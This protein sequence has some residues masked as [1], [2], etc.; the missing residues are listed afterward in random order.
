MTIR[1]HPAVDA[2]VLCVALNPAIDLTI[3]VTNLRPG[4][5][6]RAQRAQQ[7]A[8]GKGIN[9]ASCL[10]D[11]GAG[12]A[13]MMEA[14]RILK[15]VGA[16][17]NRTIRVAL[18]TGE[19]QG[20]IGSQAYVAKHF[21]AYPEPTDPAQKALPAA[22]RTNKGKLV[23]TGDYEKITAYFN[24]DNGSGKIR[25]IYAQ[26]NLA[27]APIFEEWLK[28][29]ND[30]GATIVTQRNT[31]STDHVSFD[32]VGI[33]GFQFVQDQL[34]YFSHVHHTHLDVQDHAVADDLKQASAI[35]A[36]F[37]YNAAQRP[38]KLPRKMMVED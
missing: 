20:L 30:V 21:A 8:G 9:V 33:P 4:E 35:V 31:G 6:N 15:A 24:L 7:D 18:W 37:V 17:P 10:A 13:V 12:V 11:Y 5:V 32:R 38:G 29:W 36:S 3:E 22:F 14:V 27:I 34:D 25:G 28:P 2:A 16:R 19:E 23:K 26:E 1:Q